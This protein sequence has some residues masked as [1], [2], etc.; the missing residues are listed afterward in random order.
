MIFRTALLIALIGHEVG[1]SVAGKVG[2]SVAG[3]V[4]LPVAAEAGLGDTPEEDTGRMTI[5][6]RSVGK[7]Q[8][9][10]I[11]ETGTLIQS[12]NSDAMQLGRGVYTSN[13]PYVFR[14]D[15][16]DTTFI[17][18]VEEQVFKR[19]PKVWIPREYWIGE[20]EKGDILAE[21][22]VQIAEEQLEAYIQD[23]GLDPAGTMRLGIIR[24]SKSQSEQMLIPNEM[25]GYDENGNLVETESELGISAKIPETL[26]PSGIEYDKWEIKGSKT[27]TERELQARTKFLMDKVAEAATEAGQH[28][29]SDSLEAEAAI[30][31]AVATAKKCTEGI[32]HLHRQ[33]FYTVRLDVFNSAYKQ[34]AETRKTEVEFRKHRL[35]RDLEAKK[36]MVAVAAEKAKDPA[37]RAS[38]IAEAKA[39]REECKTL[40]QTAEAEATSL[41]TA[42]EKVDAILQV[43]NGGEDAAHIL[44]LLENSRAVWAKLQENFF[45]MT[46]EKEGSLD[47]AIKDEAAIAKEEYTICQA[48]VD[49][50]KAIVGEIE[51]VIDALPLPET[52]QE[53]IEGTKEK[54]KTVEGT[55]EKANALCKRGDVDCIQE[56]SKDAAITDE[57]IC[58]KFAEQ[59]LDAMLVKY[60]AGKLTTTSGVYRGIKAKFKGYTTLT[61]GRIPTKLGSATAKAGGGALL[62]MSVGFWVKNVVEV[63]KQNTTEMQRAAVV[64][65]IFPFVGCAVQAGAR[66]DSG[67]STGLV[68]GDSVC[69]VADGLLL[70]PAWPV[71]L[72]LHGAR[73]L[74]DPEW[75]YLEEWA[76]HRAKAKA[77]LESQN[78]TDNVQSE[79]AARKLGVLFQ[80]ARAAGA[81]RLGAA[82]AAIANA[83]SG[84][85]RKQ[86]QNQNSTHFVG[87]EEL[88]SEICVQLL[89]RRRI[90]QLQVEQQINEI[91]E[92]QYAQFDCEFWTSYRSFW[93]EANGWA[94]I[95]SKIDG[96]LQHI[97][98]RYG[99]EDIGLKPGPEIAPLIGPL[100]QKIMDKVEM[101]AA[102]RQRDQQLVERH[103]NEDELSAQETPP[104]YRYDRPSQDL[105]HRNLEEDALS[106]EEKPPKY[107]YD[108]LTCESGLVRGL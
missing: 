26:E 94:Y 100:A 57:K 24:A 106:A 10:I 31:D 44:A 19:T 68:A 48:A 54:A 37:N 60:G 85:E 61:P 81:L 66:V 95:P 2:L 79:F 38:G 39:A 11:E 64:T 16:T 35:R 5:G 21:R 41:K 90:L 76:K 72:V 8:K 97:K 3:K 69:L 18:S 87:S 104:R 88:Y 50:A 91:L 6:Y 28:L 83:T 43:L 34:Y 46:G 65:S 1:L 78:L 52:G 27:F 107:K 14:D 56:L 25:I 73:P 12:R 36:R 32:G 93:T 58:E 30:A 103:W 71:G 47:A 53:P 70:T 23:Q 15:V 45:S 75:H 4:G 20:A 77:M 13:S 40:L 86:I 92:K 108:R 105:V 67:K 62:A 17:I 96:Y 63:F 51:Q 80:G 42:H 102:C 89:E 82:R 101:P 9:D 29:V 33:N 84:E 59:T 98:D 7:A 22:E 74:F 55:G 99:R 49:A